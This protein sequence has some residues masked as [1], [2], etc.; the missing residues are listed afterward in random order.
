MSEPLDPAMFDDCTDP[1]T[2]PIRIGDKWTAQILVCLKDSPRRFGELRAPLHR[3][4][5]KVLSESLR[6]L[7]RDG[8]VTRT[9]YDEH[10]PR[11]EYAL[12]SLGRSLLEPMA[13]GCAWSR[14]NAAELTKA[15]ANR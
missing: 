6:S 5:P 3:L 13:A 4:T 10:P 2:Q 14:A 7:V 15:R 12:T 1:S 11:V 8:F 9:A